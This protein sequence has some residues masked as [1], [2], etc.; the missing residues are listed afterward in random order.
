MFAAIKSVKE[1]DFVG[2]DIQV[3]DRFGRVIT[4]DEL[5]EWLDDD[6]EEV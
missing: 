5:E 3:V 2:F 4:S 6:V 1:S